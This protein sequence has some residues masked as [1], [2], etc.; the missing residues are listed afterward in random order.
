MNSPPGGGGEYYLTDAFQYM[1]D[2]GAKLKID[3]RGGLVR[4]GQAGDAAG[5][6]P[7]VLGTTRGRRP[8]TPGDGVTIVIPCTSPTA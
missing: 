6:Q 3:R 4:R 1:V 7:H 5:D 2:H 8:Q